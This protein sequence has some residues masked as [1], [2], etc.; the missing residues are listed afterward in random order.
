MFSHTSDLEVNVIFLMDVKSRKRIRTRR[1]L[2]PNNSSERQSDLKH[3]YHNDI[4]RKRFISIGSDFEKVEQAS[5]GTKPKLVRIMHFLHIFS[6]TI[7][8]AC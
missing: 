8:N 6:C 2:L 4:S 5:Y 3:L 7:L 1:R